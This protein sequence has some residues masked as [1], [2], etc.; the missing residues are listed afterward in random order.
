MNTFQYVFTNLSGANQLS[1]NGLAYTGKVQVFKNGSILRDGTDFTAT[2]GS[3]VQLTASTVQSDVYVVQTFTGKELRAKGYD[4]VATAGQSIF[5]GPD[6]F[7][8]SLAY[9]RNEVIVFLNGVALVDSADYTASSGNSITLTTPAA[10]NDELKVITYVPQDLSSIASDLNLKNFEFT[11]DSGQ[12][13][14]TGADDNGSTL[15][16]TAGLVNVS[17]NG[18]LL[19]SSDFTST[20]GSTVVLT[21]AADSGDILIVTRLTGNNLGGLDSAN[22][23]DAITN[24]VTAPYI[25]ALGF[26]NTSG[27]DSA[28]VQTMVDSALFNWQE[29]SV[30]V[31]LVAGQKTIVDTSATPITIGLPTGTFGNEVRIIDGYGNAATNNI[32]I[33]SSQKIIGSDS[34]LIININR[35]AIGLV[36]YNDS[37]G[38][39]LTE[40]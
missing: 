2:D 17:L 12:S 16:Y 21:E 9:N 28:T 20:D 8:A 39:I 4:F 23:N 34:D 32:T 33:Q 35:A 14:F 5:N 37:N 29:A 26:G 24:T 36:Y 25:A 19:K 40:N 38:W 7:G 6:R 1:G 3:T 30:G 11:A 13:T 10:L 27:T 31:T 18:L 15:V 22:V